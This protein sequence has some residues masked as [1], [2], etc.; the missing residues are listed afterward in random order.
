MTSGDQ[1]KFFLTLLGVGICLYTLWPS[2]QFYALSP[3]KRREVL[4]A[5][6]AAAT[7]TED[8]ERLEKLAKLRDKAIKLGLDLQGGMYLLLEVDRSKLG[9][10]EAKNAVDQ[11]MQII[12]NRIDQFGAA[13]PSIQ[14]Q[15][16]NRILI[17]LPGLLDQERA[18]GLIGQTALLEFK[19]VKTDE[20]SRALFDRI[21][22]YFSRRLL[23]GA[24]ADTT[25]PDSLRHPFSSRLLIRAENSE[26]FVL[27]ENEAVVEN[28]LSAI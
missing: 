8:R 5:N 26:S 9:P 1:R 10:A 2:F 18:K 12:R 3:D 23:G 13:E 25:A 11:A 6:P 16:E 21:D 4:Q 14:Q 28:M 24:Q 7:T 17:Q 15:G 19:L 22:Q 20:E 27:S